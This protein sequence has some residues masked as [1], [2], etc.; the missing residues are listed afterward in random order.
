[1][2]DR[3]M[4]DCSAALHKWMCKLLHGHSI[5]D[6]VRAQSA[7]RSVLVDSAVMDPLCAAWNPVDLNPIDVWHD[8]RQDVVLSRATNIPLVMSGSC[9]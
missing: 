1:M 5:S 4:L 7:V 3:H 6:K 8:T 9:Q 2:L